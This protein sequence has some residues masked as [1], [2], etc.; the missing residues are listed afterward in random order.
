[1][2]DLSQK[3]HLPELNECEVEFLHEYCTVLK[4]IAMAIDKFQGEHLSFYGYAIPALR[5]TKA[6]LNRIQYQP[7][8]YNAQLV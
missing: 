4:P 1:M 3:L 2:K 5:Q 7:L 6:S 8:K